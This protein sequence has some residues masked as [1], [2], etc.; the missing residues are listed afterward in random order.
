MRPT[1]RELPEALKQD[2]EVRLSQNLLQRQDATLTCMASDSQQLHQRSNKLMTSLLRK[3]LQLTLLEIPLPSR[4]ER[5]HAHLQRDV[6]CLPQEQT[7]TQCEYT[8][9]DPVQICCV[10]APS[11]WYVCCTPKQLDTPS[12]LQCAMKGSSTIIV[13]VLWSISC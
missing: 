12:I 10:C 2:H 13:S 4:A 11:A 1:Y 8:F 5:D 9:T 3:R 7:Q 6:R